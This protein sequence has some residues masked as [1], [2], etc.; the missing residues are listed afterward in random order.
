MNFF[1]VVAISVSLSWDLVDFCKLTLASSGFHRTLEQSRLRAF[2][3]QEATL[4]FKK[5]FLPRDP[6]EYP[7]L[8]KL[9]LFFPVGFHGNIAFR[10]LYYVLRYFPEA[11]CL[12]LHLHFYGE[13]RSPTMRDLFE[14]LHDVGCAV[15]G[16]NI[17]LC[18]DKGRASLWNS[19]LLEEMYS[20]MI[21]HHVDVV[22]VYKRQRI[23][24]LEAAVSALLNLRQDE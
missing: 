18:F 16:L 13:V 19:G 10:T 22:A 23:T 5:S 12:H 20:L 14:L 24:G 3:M 15:H 7:N 11:C 4:V 2:V 17:H 6:L 9:T 21:S 1:A 8:R